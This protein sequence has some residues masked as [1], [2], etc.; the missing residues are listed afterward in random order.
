[1]PKPIPSTI[2]LQVFNGRE[3]KLNKAIFQILAL[4]GPQTI[5]DIH[6]EVRARRGLTQTRY[7]NVN[8]R[9]G[10]L[11]QSGYIDQ[12]GIRKTKAG[13]A[14]MTYELTTK[15]YLAILLDSTT[16]LDDLISCMDEATA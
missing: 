7:A 16:D 11:E 12:A 1:M 10:A 3:A 14:A 2:K 5:Y 9:V 15:T 4:K 13:F 6:K 8:I